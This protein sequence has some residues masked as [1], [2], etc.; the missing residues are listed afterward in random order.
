MAM[1]VNTL[2]KRSPNWIHR[3]GTYGKPAYATFAFSRLERSRM[4]P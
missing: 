4:E 1:P 3:S 2:N